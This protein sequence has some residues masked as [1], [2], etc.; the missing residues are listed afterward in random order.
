M[1]DSSLDLDL[2]ADPSAPVTTAASSTHDI[3]LDALLAR[4][5]PAQQGFVACLVHSTGNVQALAAAGSGKTTSMVA[6][7]GALLRS[8]LPAE[9][10]I[11]TTFTSKA[12]KELAERLGA[13]VPAGTLASLRVG[14][15]HGLGIRSLKA[16]GFSW[17]M[18]Y[19][20]DVDGRAEGIPAARL[21]WAKVL[22]WSEIPGLREKGLDINLEEKGLSF[23]DYALAAD[24]IRSHG[25]EQGTPE[26]Q[27]AAEDIR[28]PAFRAAWGLYSA[29]KK[30]LGAWDFA[31]VL[32]RWVEGLRAG[33]VRDSARIVLVDEAQDNSRVQLEIAKLLARGG[34][35]VLVGDVRQ[36]IYSWRGAD[37]DVFASAHTALSAERVELPNNYRS[38]SRIVAVGNAIADGQPWSVGTPAEPKRMLA[39][40]VAILGGFQTPFQEAAEVAHRITA[41]MQEGERTDSFAILTRTNAM[42]G[43]FEAELVRLRVPCIVVGGMPF[44]KRKEVL[45][46]LA[47]AA[48]IQHD[49]VNQLERVCNRPKRFLGK[50]FIESV[51]RE[52]GEG[53]DILAT[54]RA[55]APALR[56]GSRQGAEDLAQDIERLREVGW[57][58]AEDCAAGEHRA[59]GLIVGMLRP[60]NAGEDAS[61]NDVEG[62]YA[63]AAGIAATFASA[64]ELVEFALLCGST[65]AA[66]GESGDVAAASTGRV[67][68]STIHKAKGLEWKNL[69][70]STSEGVFPHR[71]SIEAEMKGDATRMAEER[72]L[73]YVAVT[74]AR[75]SLTCTWSE[76]NLYGREA[77][78]SQFLTS[79]EPQR[80]DLPPATPPEGGES[81]EPEPTAPAPSTSSPP[82]SVPAQP[83]PMPVRY[84]GTTAE[85]ERILRHIAAL[86]LAGK[87]VA[88]A[89]VL[90]GIDRA[91]ADRLDATLEALPAK[92][93]ETACGSTLADDILADLLTQVGDGNDGGDDGPPDS[94][95]SGEPGDI[96]DGDDPAMGGTGLS[97]FAGHP[98]FPGHNSAAGPMV[99][100]AVARIVNEAVLGDAERFGRVLTFRAEEIAPDKVCDI[101]S[102]GLHAARSIATERTDLEPRADASGGEGSR[103]VQVH[104][105]SFDE[106]LTPLDFVEAGGQRHQRVWNGFSR[107]FPRA[108]IKVYSTVPAGDSLAREVGEDSIRIAAVWP[109][110]SGESKPILPKEAW[111]CRTRGW[112]GSL[113][114]RIEK[115]EAALARIPHCPMC[116]AP[117]RLREGVS[118]RS[119]KPYKFYSC[120]AWTKDGGGCKGTREAALDT[121]ELDLG[122]DAGGAK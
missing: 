57:P 119:G 108:V 71:R 63:A 29:A 102:D 21:L 34:R 79:V 61:D 27:R 88:T 24:V 54:I 81:A 18:R 46:V 59:L 83:A 110:G 7:I 113:L 69:Y 73:F 3:A 31:D 40:T 4:L 2:G 56:G 39:G 17:D 106:L 32:A 116:D 8:G 14:T 64:K 97:T 26:A 82:P 66:V 50:A 105:D 10:I 60:R 9:G 55:V 87:P 95:P 72:R 11:A 38:G 93:R 94:G 98:P 49:S 42:S 75:D 104:A 30:S 96:A 74:R 90:P 107:A 70:V 112:R 36:A 22:G 84:A 13:I 111:V 23:G 44:F 16:A 28:L 91:G 45:D 115:V 114:D 67:T 1:T 5:D 48:L 37:P 65:V 77:G 89:M 103:Y 58:T 118:R 109:M 92:V 121:V 86:L 62:L 53:A 52:H 68:I 47:Y 33:T 80:T 122:G 99:S 41:S 15:F 51:R 43:P 35:L 20:M 6:G 101:R 12:G 78:P 120:I 19:C 117:M 25:L 100:P 85:V 76:E